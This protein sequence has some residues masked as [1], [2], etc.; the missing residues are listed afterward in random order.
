MDKNRLN[1]KKTRINTPGETDF[2]GRDMAAS[3]ESAKP[4]D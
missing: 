4:L 3:L 1:R 2:G